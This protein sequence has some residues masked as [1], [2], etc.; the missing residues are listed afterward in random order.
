MNLP[1]ILYVSP[2]AF[3]GGAEEFVLDN[4]KLL[5]KKG[6][7][8]GQVLF[9]SDGPVAEDLREIGIKVHILPFKFKIR[10]PLTVIRTIIYLFLLLKR[11][12]ISL[13]HSTMSYAHIISS[14]AALLA[15]VP[16]IWFQ[17]GAVK[18]FGII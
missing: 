16:E 13:L 6:R 15:A 17:H 18:I 9:F 7:F 12:K 3:R 8:E 5:Q 14:P 2:N 10:R 11:E 1:R 4:L